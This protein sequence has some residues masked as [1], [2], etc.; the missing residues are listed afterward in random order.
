MELLGVVVEIGLEQSFCNNP[1]ELLPE[2]MYSTARN[3]GPVVNS[4]QIQLRAQA[5]RTQAQD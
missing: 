4:S 5:F 1:T 3:N 2:R